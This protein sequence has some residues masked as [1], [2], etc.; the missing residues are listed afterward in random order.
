MVGQREWRRRNFPV[1]RDAFEAKFSLSLSM[2]VQFC[3]VVADVVVTVVVAVAD[4]DAYV[5]EQF[6]RA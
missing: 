5:G 2:T 3:L 6:G 4:D 1:F